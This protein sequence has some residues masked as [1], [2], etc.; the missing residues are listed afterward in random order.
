[1]SPDD[2]QRP[3]R[4]SDPSERQPSPDEHLSSPAAVR[5][6]SAVGR[7]RGRRRRRHVVRRVVGVLLLV[8]AALAVWVGVRGWLAKDHLERAAVLV[9]RLEQQ[10]RAGAATS[11][12]LRTLQ[13]ETG[14]ARDLTGDPVWSSAM[15]LPWIGDDLSAVRAAAVAVDVVARDAVPPLLQVAD[16]LEPAALRPKDGRVQLEPLVKAQAPLRAAD[17]ALARAT[18]VI[19]PFVGNGP[20]SGSLL[21]PVDHALDGLAAQIHKVARDTATGGRAADLLPPMLGAG[22]PRTYLVLFQNLAEARS[23]GGIAGAYALVHADEGRL[24]ITKQG[25]GADIPRFDQ[26]VVDLGA[27]AEELYQ[28]KPTRYFVDV[29]QVIDFTK[30][31]RIAQTMWAERTGVN[32]DGVLAVDPVALSYLLRA[33][34]PVRLP[35]GIE[36]TTDKVVDLLLSDVYAQIPNPQAQNAFFTV[37]ALAVFQRVLAGTGDADTMLQALAQAGGEHRLLAW[38][39][40]AAEQ[41]RLAGTVL[42]GRLPRTESRRPTLGVFFNEGT[43]SKLSYYLRAAADVTGGRCRNDGFRELLL[44]LTLSSTA[45][46]HGLS[47]Y[48]AG[49]E[50]PYV[51]EPVVYLAAP[52]AGGLVDVAVDGKPRPVNSQV[53]DGRTVAATGLRIP[54]GAEVH[55]RARYVVPATMHDA[56]LR[57][58][59]GVSPIATSVRIAS[60]P[61][62]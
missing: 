11:G 9:P 47:A 32:V 57:T 7:G 27:R 20:E 62:L 43:A 29:T 55:L 2:E 16:T 34:G 59:P 22:G 42:E 6:T 24:S 38:S 30:S 17:R 46:S 61:G 51:M 60:C 1:V 12:D 23:L 5:P 52:L 49:T 53:V 31:A 36:L 33:S 18:T 41:E 39:S 21:P 45:P 8:V 44:D 54:P 15:H 3:S 13:R 37:T 50:E 26:P 58:T 28:S 40:H 19:D 35:G 48:V 10:A 14:A 25:S 4:G 56:A